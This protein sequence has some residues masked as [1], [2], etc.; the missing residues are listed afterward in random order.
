VRKEAGADCPGA[1]LRVTLLNGGADGYMP[2]V[3]GEY[4]T[5]ERL[6]SLR[7]GGFNGYKLLDANMKERSRSKKDL[8]AMLDQLNIQ[9]ENPVAVLDQEEAKKFLTGKE[10]DKYAFFVKATELERLDRVYASVQDNILEQQALQERA[11]EG[12][13]GAIENTKRL[14][15]EWEQFRELDKLEMEA[16]E[17]R[18]MY[19]WGCHREFMEQLNEEMKVRR[20]RGRREEGGVHRRIDAPRSPHFS[21]DPA[22]LIF[23]VFL[24]RRLE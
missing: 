8:D 17:L 14:K 11:R 18:A 22:P 20:D 2:D 21:S 24:R 6:I 4:I 19:G 7:P 3:Y 10:E 23:L 15:M 12:V 13:G 5:V 1:K 9:V 16:Q